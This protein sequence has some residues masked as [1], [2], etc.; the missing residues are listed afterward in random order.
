VKVESKS[1]DANVT[2][3]ERLQEPWRFASGDG[4]ITQSNIDQLKKAFCKSRFDLD[5]NQIN[6]QIKALEKLSR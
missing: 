1:K 4:Q 6:D 3:R 5:K 2:I